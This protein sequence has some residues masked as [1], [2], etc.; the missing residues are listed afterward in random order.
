MIL[1]PTK[2]ADTGFFVLSNAGISSR[3]IVAS[4]RNWHNIFSGLLNSAQHC[5]K[6]P[7]WLLDREE[8]GGEVKEEGGSEEKK[9]RERGSQKE[10]WRTSRQMRIGMDLGT[11]ES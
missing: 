7:Q 6:S 11:D 4:R 8:H 9:E 10:K 3:G 1:G 5:V 2:Q